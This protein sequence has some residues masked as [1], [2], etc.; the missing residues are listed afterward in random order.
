[1]PLNCPIRILKPFHT[2]P[3]TRPPPTSPDSHYVST[4]LYT[5]SSI[6]VIDL[7]IISSVSGSSAKTSKYVL[8][9][10][11]VR[12]WRLANTGHALK[13]VLLEIFGKFRVTGHHV[14]T[15]EM[16]N[17]SRFCVQ[18]RLKVLPYVEEV[19]CNIS[20]TDH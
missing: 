1:L 17:S 11:C 14:H 12:V 16:M 3:H 15:V 2:A 9:S 19:C 20:A 6:C 5:S 18:A 8:P 10:P 7:W 13:C 4:L